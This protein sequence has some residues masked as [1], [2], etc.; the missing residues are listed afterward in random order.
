M[1]GAAAFGI[2]VVAT[3][4]AVGAGR[5][6]GADAPAADAALSA[7][8]SAV[9][10][11]LAVIDAR[12]HRVPN[13]I[14]FPA[15]LAAI[16]VTPLWPERSLA[17][18]FAS[19][20]GAAAAWVG[21]LLCAALVLR[22]AGRPQRLSDHLRGGDI[23]LVALIGLLAPWPLLGAAALA[24][25]AAITLSLVAVAAAALAGRLGPGP[26]LVPLAPAFAAGAITA[27]VIA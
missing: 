18:A 1:S 20:A 22:L 19:G 27:L 25:L 3:G 7:A 5:W 11:A 9:L 15:L 21:A 16:A 8:W 23:K 24:V 2:V 6:F 17:V 14:I 13:R 4:A 26:T 10:A 12:T